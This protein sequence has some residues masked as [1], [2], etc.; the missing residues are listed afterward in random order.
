MS[1][2]IERAFGWDDEI[3]KD[4][5]D[6]ILLAEGDYDFVVKEFERARHNGSANLP[7]CNKAIVTL[8]IDA[9]EGVCRIKHNIFL[10]TKTEGLISAFFSA[11]GQK[12]KGE[13]LQMNWSAIMDA[14]GRCKVGVR[15]WQ[16]QDNEDRQSNEIKKFY[17]KEEGKPISPSTTFTPGEF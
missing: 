6:Y 8:E 12:K 15:K 9:P 10:H 5:S 3:E 7:A 17:P 14:T 4:N 16:N 2:L 1:D 13:K 11:I